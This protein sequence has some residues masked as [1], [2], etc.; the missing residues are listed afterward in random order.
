[1]DR[2]IWS[3][4]FASILGLIVTCTSGVAIYLLRKSREPEA[5]G[6]NMHRLDMPC[7]PPPLVD[8]VPEHMTNYGTSRGSRI[9]NSSALSAASG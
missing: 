6:V 2:I 4:L 8:I 7:P 1:M 3:D 5:Q 9:Y